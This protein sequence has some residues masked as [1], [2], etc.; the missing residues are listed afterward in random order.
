MSKLLLDGVTKVYGEGESAVTALDNV[1]LSVEPGEL[2]AIVGPSGSGKTTFLAIAGA[3]LQPTRGRVL[4][5]GRDL[6]GLSP[7]AL[8][9]VRLEQI[10]FVLQSANLIP[11]LRARDQLLLVAEIAG[12][13]DAAANQRADALLAALGLARRARHYPE[14]L[15]GGE[16]Q[17]VAIARALMND[18]AL[19]LADEPTAS[20][21]SGRG[22]EVVELLAREVHE[23]D[24]A[25]LL[26]THDE[27]MLDLCDRV[28][29]IADGRLTERSAVAP[30]SAG[31]V[32]RRG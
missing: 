9:Q 19:L 18:P 26:V 1:S 8:A 21:D 12:R 3:L 16:R 20:L 15:S 17:R 14:S 13:R 4:L 22:R 10:G 7:A 5:D 27:R 29:H 31:L 32:G 6:T 11:G 23:R 30:V 2:V 25:G 24:K 28:I